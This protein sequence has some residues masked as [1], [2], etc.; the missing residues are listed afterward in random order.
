MSRT[1][2][3]SLVHHPAS[4]LSVI[5]GHLEFERGLRHAVR[6][7][8]RVLEYDLIQFTRFSV[9]EEPEVDNESRIDSLGH[10]T[11]RESITVNLQGYIV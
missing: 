11:I 7:I 10:S 9:S 4:P 6:I 2:G 5:I 3:Y 1:S 8:V